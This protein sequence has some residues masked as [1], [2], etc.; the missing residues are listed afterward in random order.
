YEEVVVVNAHGEIIP[1]PSSYSREGW[2][3]KIAEAMLTRRVTWVHTA[4][5]PFYHAWYEGA[6]DKE[7]PAWGAA[8]FKRLMSAIN[9]GDVTCWPP[10]EETV[11]VDI[12]RNAETNLLAGGWPDLHRCFFVERGRP[13]NGS[14]F[15]EYLAL[16][17]WGAEYYPGAVIRYPSSNT[18]NFGF[19]AHVGTNRTYDLDQV[20]TDRDLFRG[21]AA[22]AAA[23]YT[24]GGRLAAEDSLAKAVKAITAAE[25]EGRTRGLEEARALLKEAWNEYYKPDYIGRTSADSL[26]HKAEEASEEAVKPSFLESYGPLTL[27]AVVAVIAGIVIVRWRRNSKKNEDRT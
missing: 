8:G 10:G 14:H 17:L 7:T 5:Y 20:A 13:L 27:G 3:D 4:G 19:Y 9:L 2:T 21:Y 15:Q 1:V 16:P 18:S 25:E 26:A 6:G 24:V 11:K 12:T 22:A 23:I